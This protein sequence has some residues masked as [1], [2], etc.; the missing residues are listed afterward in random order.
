[1]D[2]QS[3]FTARLDGVP[4]PEV[5]Q[6][7]SHEG[8]ILISH[9]ENTMPGHFSQFLKTGNRSPGLLIVPQG[10]QAGPVIESI[11]LIW[12]ASEAEDWVT[13]SPGSLCRN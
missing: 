2:F 12:I 7:C 4:D 3:A 5:L 10:S 11:L 9:D 6:L 13:E 8:R 1:M